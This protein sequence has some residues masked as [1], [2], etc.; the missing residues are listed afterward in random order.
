[1]EG[2][3]DK[4]GCLWIKRGK[5]FKRAGCPRSIEILEGGGRGWGVCGD[6]CRLFGDPVESNLAVGGKVILT[7]CSRYQDIFDGF[8]D[9]RGAEEEGE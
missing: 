9:E 7:S 2:K 3:I 6:W 1:M 8:T 4:Y 5:E